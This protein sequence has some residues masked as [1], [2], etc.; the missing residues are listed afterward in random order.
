MAKLTKTELLEME[1]NHANKLAH[2]RDIKVSELSKTNELLNLKIKQL[3]TQVKLI[4]MDR[5]I[6]AKKVKLGNLKEDIR[7]FNNKI[8]AK[9]KIKGSFG[10]NPDTGEILKEELNGN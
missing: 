8:K 2:D 4:G 9:H 1:L 10:I 7:E 6:E 3:E 5:E